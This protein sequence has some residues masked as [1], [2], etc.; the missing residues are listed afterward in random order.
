MKY[1]AVATVCI[2]I[3][4]ILVIYQFGT[5]KTNTTVTS[6]KLIPP[7]EQKVIQPLNID[8]SSTARV[9][10]HKD[11]SEQN[12]KKTVQNSDVADF[13]K[14]LRTTYV[15]GVYCQQVADDGT[16]RHQKHYFY[17]M[18]KEQFVEIPDVYFISNTS[19]LGD[20]RDEYEKYGSK[21]DVITYKGQK[22]KIWTMDK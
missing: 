22:I 19:T 2:V 1:S 16:Y 14:K 20:L 3:A 8:E 4:G 7:K 17:N 12:F 13:A 6:R 15:P 18:K 21:T 9:V 10:L 11:R 5:P